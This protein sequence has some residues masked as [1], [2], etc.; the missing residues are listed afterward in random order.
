MGFRN[1]ANV[2]FSR[3]GLVN[4]AS[5]GNSEILHRTYALLTGNLQ[6]LFMPNG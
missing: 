2:V 4:S 1:A 5:F 6:M 3:G